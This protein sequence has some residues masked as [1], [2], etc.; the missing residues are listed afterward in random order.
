MHKW[1]KSIVIITFVKFVRKICGAYADY[2]NGFIQLASFIIYYAKLLV[3]LGA[4]GIKKVDLSADS[5]SEYRAWP[6]GVGDHFIRVL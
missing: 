3:L 1:Q 4:A 6:I 5:T 2:R